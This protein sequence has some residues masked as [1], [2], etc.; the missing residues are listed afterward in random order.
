VYFLENIDYWVE[1]TDDI[2]MHRKEKGR[3]LLVT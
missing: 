2:K 1:T 3:G